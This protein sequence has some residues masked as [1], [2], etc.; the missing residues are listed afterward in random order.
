MKLG[1]HKTFWSSENDSA[2][3]DLQYP[4]A[5]NTQFFLF[6]NSDTHQILLLCYLLQKG[7]NMLYSQL[8]L[9]SNLWA[10]PD[11]RIAHR[12]QLYLEA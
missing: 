6:Y 2:S 8:Y 5:K 9:S 12:I 11:S 7:K 4:Y 3:L 10:K 1:I